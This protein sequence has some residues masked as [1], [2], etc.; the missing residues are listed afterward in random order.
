MRAVG[1][2]VMLIGILGLAYGEWRAY[3]PF[4]LNL[5]EARVFGGLFVALG[6]MTILVFRG[7]DQN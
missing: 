6:A 3:V 5:L 7:Q 4:H 1:L 2:F